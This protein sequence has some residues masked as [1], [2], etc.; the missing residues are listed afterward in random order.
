[1]CADSE[2]PYPSNIPTQNNGKDLRLVSSVAMRIL[3]RAEK[4]TGSPRLSPRKR[5]EESEV[6]HCWCEVWQH[7][8]EIR[9]SSLELHISSGKEQTHLS[10]H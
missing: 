1:M 9:L 2:T 5:H 7:L 8:V 3:P 6:R 4:D 10:A